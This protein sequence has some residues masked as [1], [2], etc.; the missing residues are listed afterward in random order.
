MAQTPQVP[1]R[2]YLPGTI[3]NLA[4]DPG[5]PRLS[6]VAVNRT[7]SGISYVASMRHPTGERSEKEYRAEELMLPAGTIS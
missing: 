1:T 5:G 7:A 4:S 6:I 3:V 2:A